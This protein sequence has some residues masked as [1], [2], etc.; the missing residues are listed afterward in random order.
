V[1]FRSVNFNDPK[2]AARCSVVGS[3][4]TNDLTYP[5]ST[6]EVWCLSVSGV[7]WAHYTVLNPSSTQQQFEK[8]AES[9]V[10]AELDRMDLQ[11][12]ARIAIGALDYSTCSGLFHGSNSPGEVLSALVNGTFAGSTLRFGDLGAPVGGSVTAAL[13]TPILGSQTI[14]GVR[15]SVFTGATITINSNGQAPWAAGY[16]NRFKLGY[17]TT[18][19]T[20]DIYRA[21]TVIDE[22]GH[23]FADVTGMRGS[24]ILDDGTAPGVS[25]QNTGLVY[26]QC[27]SSMRLGG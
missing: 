9:S 20:Q 3:F 26:E 19:G 22:L 1:L 12:V 2:G 17:P 15:T 5:Y 6:Y 27:F 10:G 13:T 21:M 24:D 7:E 23:F 8:D 4:T 11:R 25:R 18:T 14:N 16:P